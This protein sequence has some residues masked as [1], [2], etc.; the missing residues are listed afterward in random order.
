M[1]FNLPAGDVCAAKFSDGEWYRAKVEKVAGG[2]VRS[3]LKKRVNELTSN[4]LF[5][6]Y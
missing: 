2:Q 6:F 5:K 3:F 4:F 1:T